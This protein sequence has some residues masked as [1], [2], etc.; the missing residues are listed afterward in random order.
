[1]PIVLILWWKKILKSFFFFI[2]LKPLM[3]KREKTSLTHQNLVIQNGTWQDCQSHMKG[4]KFNSSSDS[5]IFWLSV[6]TELKNTEFGSLPDQYMFWYLTELKNIRCSTLPLV[7]GMMKRIEIPSWFLYQRS[8][9]KNVD[10]KFTTL[11]LIL[12]S[13]FYF[14]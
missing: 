7:S 1:V 13:T 9:R 12:S 6:L 4:D 2:T 8:Y 14:I 11:F 3:C 10:R 5:Y